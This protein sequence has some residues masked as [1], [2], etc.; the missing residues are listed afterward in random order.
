MSNPVE[1]DTCVPHTQE[2]HYESANKSLKMTSET[3]ETS[4]NESQDFRLVDSEGD[5]SMV[6]KLKQILVG[7]ANNEKSID[8][9]DSQQIPETLQTEENNT[10]TA[11]DKE[12]ETIIDEKVKESDAIEKITENVS[13]SELCESEKKDELFDEDEIIQGTP[14]QSYSPSRKVGSVDVNLKRKASTFDE[15]P[16]KIPRMSEEDEAKLQKRLEEESRQ[17]CGSD[18][19]YQDLF[20]NMDKNVIIEETQEPTTVEFTQN[21][22]KTS[23]EHAAETTNDDKTQEH[24]V[25]QTNQQQDEKCDMEKDE[26]LN[27]S[28]KLDVSNNDSTTV[29]FNSTCENDLLEENNV[30]NGKGDVTSTNAVIEKFEK[31]T[32]DEPELVKDTETASDENNQSNCV[33]PTEKTID[34]NDEEIPSLQTKSRSSVEL[35]SIEETDRIID[36]KSKQQIV[37][38]DDDDEKILNSS[39]EVIYDRQSVKKKPE[40][41]QIDDS[42]EDG[43][44]ILSLLEKKEIEVSE[45]QVMDKSYEGKSSYE[46]KSSYEGKSSYKESINESSQ[47]SKSSEKRLMNGS[48]ESKKIDAD[49]TVSLDS[50]TFSLSEEQ[51]LSAAATTVTLDNIKQI[52]LHEMKKISGI[53]S[54]S[55]E[56][57]NLD[58][59]EL[60]SISDHETSNVEEKNKSDLIDNTLGKTKQVSDR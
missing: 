44:K 40:V 5:E 55:L 53:K 46:S 21:T 16:V 56:P 35:I 57:K 43:E 38:I 20:K 49:T 4:L 1:S 48:A 2:T 59:I 19:S 58:N 28:A 47:E 9:V 29:N 15:P 17:S 24:H 18:D 27:V 33:K 54:I 10:I 26:N 3:Q 37:E 34:K 23:A 41:V 51:L 60:I 30:S 14:P 42:H 45:I 8:Q 32:L 6:D 25:E 22:L 7:E 13:T 31:G 39:T 52:S 50:D 36:S 12:D 11:N